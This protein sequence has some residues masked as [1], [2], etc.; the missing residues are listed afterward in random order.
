MKGLRLLLKSEVGSCC[1]IVNS[2]ESEF[3][4]FCFKLYMYTM[5][6]KQHIE[7]MESKTLPSIFP[8]I[9]QTISPKINT[10]FSILNNL[11]GES[12]R[13]VW[14]ER[15]AR[16]LFLFTQMEKQNVYCYG[17]DIYPYWQIGRA[18]V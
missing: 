12:E 16:F 11:E 4:G 17:L 8:S 3:I 1:S 7:V 9:Y 13:G 2:D 18:H 10:V 6:I 15:E 5:K 14:R